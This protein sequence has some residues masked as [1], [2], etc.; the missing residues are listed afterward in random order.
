MKINL[1]KY[2]IFRSHFAHTT[3]CEFNECVNLLLTDSNN[4][5]TRLPS[6][7][8]NAAIATEL[9]LK[10]ILISYGIHYPSKHELDILFG[11]LP[12]KVKDKVK[13]SVS[14]MMNID[15]EDFKR[16]LKMVSSSFTTWRYTFERP[17]PTRGAY[18]INLD[19]LLIFLKC[20]HRVSTDVQSKR[21]S[22]NK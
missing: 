9:F 21:G 8:V 13:D 11:L 18:I 22:L 7:I 3:A 6:K 16:N 20:C 4:S 2:R 19:F 17:G 10:S 5:Y 1:E 12:N 15:N 14:S